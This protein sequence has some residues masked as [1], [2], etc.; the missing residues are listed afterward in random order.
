MT[1]VAVIA[2]NDRQKAELTASLRAID[3]VDIVSC[4]R[5]R[6]SVG[7][8]VASHRAELVLVGGPASGNAALA[9]LRE[10]RLASPHTAVVVVAPDSNSRWL[11]QALRGGAT[12]VLT[13]ESSTKALGSVVSEVLASDPGATPVALAA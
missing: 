1:T 10:I 7:D 9:R 2:D 5:S 3:G 12:A 6:T 11:A 4:T 8:F 13:G